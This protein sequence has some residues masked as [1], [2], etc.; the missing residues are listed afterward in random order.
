MATKT[1]NGPDQ[2]HAALKKLKD[3]S[4]EKE[5]EL[6]ELVANVYE[7]LKETEEKAIEKVRDTT[8]MVNTSVHMHPWY[9]VG[10]AAALGIVVGLIL[11]R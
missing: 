11:R 6:I 10:G 2:I 4:N 9:Y 8:S 7:T 3:K 5:I 1:L